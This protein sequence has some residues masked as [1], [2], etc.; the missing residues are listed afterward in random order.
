MPEIKN[1]FTGG[2]MNKDLDERLVP[3]GEYVDAMNIQVATSEG[4]DVGTIQ[5]I[6][7]NVEG[8][9]DANYLTSSSSFAVGSIAD[10]KNDD[11]YWLVSGQAY[12]VGGAVQYID[13]DWASF[14]GLTDIIV[15]KRHIDS[16]E[17]T[18]NCELVFVD[19][20]AFVIQNNEE[21]G[22]TNTITGL[23]AEVSTQMEAGW[24]ITGMDSVNGTTSNTVTVS[25]VQQG[26]A[27]AAQNGLMGDYFGKS[28]IVPLFKGSMADDNKVIYI[29]RIHPFFNA[30]SMVG[31]EF[32]LFEYGH[33]DYQTHQI[34][35]NSMVG[36][37][38]DNGASETFMKVTF[39]NNI[40][41]FGTTNGDTSNFSVVLSNT[42]QRYGVSY[43][44]SII[45]GSIA[46]SGFSATT[47][48][49][50]IP[51]NAVWLDPHYFN[52]YTPPPGVTF[53]VGT[54]VAF[55]NTTACVGEIPANNVFVPGNT[56]TLV[57]CGSYIPVETPYSNFNITLPQQTVIYLSE[58][59]YLDDAIHDKLIISK[60]RVLNFN[61]NEYV[62]GINIIDDMLFWTDGKTEPKKINIPRSISGTTFDADGNPKHTRLINKEVGINFASNILV[63]EEHITVIRKAPLKAPFLEMETSTR[64]GYSDDVDIIARGAGGPDLPLEFGGKNT[65][66]LVS[67]RIN[68][69][70]DGGIAPNFV[71]NDVLLLAGVDDLLPDLYDLRVSIVEIQP[72]DGSYTIYVVRVENTI[73]NVIGITQWY[74]GLED[75]DSLFERKLPRFAYRYKYEDNEYSSFSPFTEV[76]FVPGEFDYHPTE[77]YNKGMTNQIKSLTIKDFVPTTIPLD[78]IQVDLLYK[79]EIDPTIY[80]LKSITP[81][82]NNL[83]GQTQNGW[84]SPGSTDYFG[85]DRGAYKVSSENISHALS[86]SQSLRVWDN[87]PK[88]AKS[89]EITGSRIVYGNYEIGYDTIQPQISTLLGSRLTSEGGMFARKS[90]KS[91]RDYDIGVVWGDKYGR[92]TP[93]KTSGSSVTV[94]KSRAENS[95]YIS[96][97]L[98]NSPVWADYYRFYVKETS[99]EYYNLAMDRWYDAGDDNVWISFPSVDRNKIDEDTY[100]V[101]KKG[102]NSDDLVLEKARYKVVAIENEAPDYIKTSY[103]LIV[104]TNQ[105]DTRPKHS[106]N[107]WGGLNDVGGAGCTAHPANAAAYM[108]APINPPIVGRKS[109]SIS[110]GNWSAPYGGG[111]GLANLITLFAEVTSNTETINNEMYVSFTKETMVGS[112][113]NVEPSDKY[114]VVDVHHSDKLDEAS[115]YVIHL[116]KPI[117]EKDEF[118]VQD[119]GDSSVG[120]I[121]LMEDDIHVLFWQKSVTNK[122]EFDGRFFVKIRYDS[123]AEDHIKGKGSTINLDLRTKAT[124]P[125]YKIEDTQLSQN[126]GSYSFNNTTQ[127]VIP[128][129]GNTT[130]SMELWESMLS[131]S[132]SSSTVTSK[133]F[134]DKASFASKQQGPQTLSSSGKLDHKSTDGSFDD[135]NGITR[136][137]Y[138]TTSS[139]NQ[140]YAADS[141]T[142]PN[143]F[144]SGFDN[145]SQYS[146]VGDGESNA[147]V[148]MRGVHPNAGGK[149]IDISYSQLGPDGPGVIAQGEFWDNGMLDWRVGVSG[150]PN[151]SQEAHVVTSLK[152]GE[153]FKFTGSEIVYKILQVNKFRLFNYHGGNTSEITGYNAPPT[154]WLSDNT[155]NNIIRN[156]ITG[157]CSFFWNEQH[158]SQ[159]MRMHRASNRRSTYR[160]KYEVDLAFSP[161][162]TD[163][164]AAIDAVNEP[165]NNISNLADAGVDVTPGGLNFLTEYSVE[166]GNPISSNPAIFETEPKEDVDIDIYYEASSSIP[167]FPLTNKNKYSFIP[168]G[169]TLVVPS[170]APNSFP[171]GV[172]IASWGDIDPISQ[173]KRIHLSQDL[174][175]DIATFLHNQEIVYVEKDNGEL[176]SFKVLNFVG[177]SNYGAIDIE[178]RQEVGL[179]WSNCWSFGNGIESNRIGDTY[180]KPYLT[181]GVTVSSSTEE[182]KETEIR[183]YGLIY[184]GIYNS[185]SGVNNLNQFIAAEKITKDINPIY[186]SIQKLHAGWGQ[187]GDLVALCEDRILKI[188]ANKDALFNAD[189]DTNIT[190]TNRVLG[191]AIPYSGEYG[192]S[193]NPES[194][195][196]EAYRI[197]FTDKV[198]GTVMRLSMDGLTPISAHGM[199]DWFKD[200]LKLSTKLMGSYDDKKEE[201]NITLRRAIPED[202]SGNKTVTF[203][204]DTK[205]WVSFK[206]FTPENAI[207]CAN[208]YYTF[209][210]GK[211]WRH[212]AEVTVD[213]KETNRNTFYG[214]HGSNNYSTFNTVLNDAPG[215][216]KSFNTINYEG[217]DS[218]IAQNFQDAQYYNLANRDGWFV[219][220]IS[221]NKEKGSLDGFIEKEGKWFNYIRGEEIQH[222]GLNPFVNSDGSSTFDQASL[223]IQG[224]GK[225]NSQPVVVDIFGCTEIG[226][227]NYD[228]A[229]LTDDGS[230][231]AFMYGCLLDSADNYN[232]I[233]NTNDGSCVWYGC[234]CPTGTYSDGCTNTTTFPSEA[235][236]YSNAA[237]PIDMVWGIQDDDSCIAIVNGCTNPG[238]FNYNPLANIDDG[239][240]E[241]VVSGCMTVTNPEAYNYD[242]IVNTNDGTCLWYGCTDPIANNYDWSTAILDYT[243][244]NSSYGIQNDGSC[245]YD[246]GCTDEDAENYDDT[247]TIDDGCEYCGNWPV[248]NVFYGISSVEDETVAGASD[249]YIDIAV[250]PPNPVY[251]DDGNGNYSGE[252]NIVTYDNSGNLVVAGSYNYLG[253]GDYNWIGLAPGD[254]FF[255]AVQDASMM[256]GAQITPCVFTGTTPIAI[257]GGSTPIL[258]CT[259]SG[260]LGQ[261]W[262]DANYT[263]IYTGVTTYPGVEANNYNNAANQDNGSCTY[264]YGC[265]D[266]TM[267]NY[268]STA[269][270]DDGSCVAFIYGCTD[271]TAVFNYN[272]S[273]NTDDGSC[274]YSGCVGGC[275]DDTACNYDVL[276]N[277][278]DGSCYGLIGA[279]PTI[280]FNLAQNTS[281]EEDRFRIK[282][283]VDDTCYWCPGQTCQIC[284]GTG[285]QQSNYPCFFSMTFAAIFPLG[286]SYS[287]TD[288]GGPWQEGSGYIEKTFRAGNGAG[289]FDMMAMGFFTDMGEVVLNW[290]VNTDDG[291]CSVSGTQ[292]IY[293][294]P[295][296]VANTPLLSLTAW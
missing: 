166:E 152:H 119:S 150:N 59:L 113:V 286:G 173:V 204:E 30:A 93:V 233:A 265:T 195:A 4:S 285:N 7:G 186:G 259:D 146:H 14:T 78:V 29:G 39:I 71:L 120:T 84:H 194:F 40:T 184:S 1:Q 147:Q 133:W 160:I 112:S 98:E 247:A 190:S 107:L 270:V 257:T 49:V 263:S 81:S 41:P 193:K 282:V 237:A 22:G 216:V 69:I 100:I 19:K 102:T 284:G 209:L 192:I 156:I 117:D 172:F 80:L 52:V 44:D 67:I 106:C 164:D 21:S 88:K 179:N 148:G 11:L 90:I 26:P 66:D 175:P 274:C 139:Q 242:A 5:N 268:D 229:A 97:T 122:P 105:D 83:P 57:E 137:A 144:T 6:L 15:R 134:V 232:P 185:T 33:P 68:H 53:G 174:D 91:L 63:K 86:S 154:W 258:G 161:S 48:N 171:T 36:I 82:D 218:K 251:M 141:C 131:F 159:V 290:T 234:T 50:S 79:N 208:E 254:Y 199:K 176:A 56:F 189:G 267:F 224:L 276:A 260:N 277:V 169:S 16:L 31:K 170:S 42:G 75:L 135:S 17:L 94:G 92:E 61:H 244:T 281:G 89:Q 25:G 32:Q 76:A 167:T 126:T 12:E 223:A 74:V 231:I 272:A 165:Y 23:P 85:A 178:P 296:G 128:P 87:V 220:S 243:P 283:G 34:A 213:G 222:A 151:T 37:T 95:S 288:L 295:N 155:A 266:A 153:R 293:V 203:R 145:F 246:V 60:P 28:I 280:T 177:G 214:V 20:F 99:N 235:M 198:R 2:K 118:V 163:P 248:E 252:I 38:Y 158:K 279:C 13:D 250:N 225:L 9:G 157:A 245:T 70:G 262:W 289:P 256:V 103:D 62:T 205:G 116:E 10:E 124:I 294:G 43:Q 127:N 219:D 197:Y 292:T 215:S 24:A 228:P 249:G 182:L 196:S 226:Q 111:M 73:D 255:Q 187:G 202:G 191:T 230:C 110:S 35:A 136:K 275:T 181:N 58:V 162:G 201:Y 54:V 77:A 217:S 261:V 121:S 132:D 188:L 18:S 239:S 96:A 273:A 238:A 183:K 47:V 206:S 129:S 207:S 109:F 72:G 180:N 200:N 55:N 125:L 227:F 221:T 114:R 46:L 64:Q 8:C 291:L 45:W 65:G 143:Y 278:D 101:L 51:N 142:F 140:Q 108:G 3:K 104:R 269:I 253:A 27:Y 168:I 149:Y 130:H 212:H 236:G 241:A 264:N 123:I 210:N 211:L 115:P 271:V 138:D 240:C 287:T